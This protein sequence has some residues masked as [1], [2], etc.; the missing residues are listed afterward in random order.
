MKTS[1]SAVSECPR[2]AFCSANDCPLSIV[3]YESLPND[4]TPKC[5]LAKS[6]RHKLGVKWNLPNQGLTS[7]ELSAKNR[8]DSLSP[9]E[10]EAKRQ[11]ARE[12]SVFLRLSQK[13]YKIVAKNKD[14]S[15]THE[16]NDKKP[17]NEALES[18]SGNEESKK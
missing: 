11:T 1:T 10:Q 17:L 5:T 15:E 7:R 13:G 16:L 4:H 9:E 3:K 6:I 8:W 12:N 18:Q 14:N 2:F